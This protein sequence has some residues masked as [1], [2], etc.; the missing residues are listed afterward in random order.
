MVREAR[1]GRSGPRELAEGR[2]RPLDIG[3]ET[4]E[5]FPLGRA[6]VSRLPRQL[7]LHPNRGQLLLHA[8][9]QVPL[10]PTAS[11]W[12]AVTT[13]ARDSK[14]SNSRLQ[15]GSSRSCAGPFPVRSL[16]MTAL[17]RATLARPGFIPDEWPGI[18]LTTPKPE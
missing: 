8:V 5:P 11:A 1:P 9:V 6:A 12:P 14:I 7:E 13:R 16:Q 17:L 3:A 10:D 4:V 18:T 2:E 15:L